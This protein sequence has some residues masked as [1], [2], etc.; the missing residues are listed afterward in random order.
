MELCDLILET[1]PALASFSYSGYPPTFA[2]FE[3]EVTPFFDSLREH[4]AESR[5]AALITEL[6]KT[7]S[8]LGR[9]EAKERAGKEKQVLALFLAP[10]AQRYGEAAQS[11]AEA[12]SRLWNARYPRNRF[13][14]GSFETI[15]KGFD[16]NLLGLPLRKSK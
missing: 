8:S 6:E 5:A 10:A 3:R 16:A 14:P 15:L 1:L 13:Y 2:A 4:E 11:F 12:L 7:R 9:R